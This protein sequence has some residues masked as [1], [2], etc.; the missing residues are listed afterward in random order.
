[1]TTTTAMNLRTGDVLKTKSGVW[2]RVTVFG[3]VTRIKRVTVGSRIDGF[4]RT[5]PTFDDVHWDAVHVVYDSVGGGKTV[6]AYYRPD[7][8]VV[9][10]GR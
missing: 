3:M 2:R 5:F 4:G 1:M 7:D 6:H 8:R 10:K 9:V